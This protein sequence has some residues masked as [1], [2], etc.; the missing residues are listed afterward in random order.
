LSEAEAAL[1]AAAL[2]A[3]ASNQAEAPAAPANQAEAPA[4]PANQQAPQQGLS[5]TEANPQLGN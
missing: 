3:E 1:A 5:L 4:A 2:L